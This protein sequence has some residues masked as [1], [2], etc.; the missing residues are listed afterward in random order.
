MESF[1]FPYMNQSALVF[2]SILSSVYVLVIGLQPWSYIPGTEA[3]ATS[4]TTVYSAGDT[5]SVDKQDSLLDID[6]IP[7][8]KE[9]NLTL[10]K[11]DNRSSF[12]IYILQGS[13]GNETA[14]FSS[15]NLDYPGKYILLRIGNVSSSEF[16]VSFVFGIDGVRQDY[17]LVLVHGPFS[18]PGWRNGTYF[19]AIS[20]NSARV[21]N[22]DDLLLF[23]NDNYTAIKNMTLVMQNQSNLDRMEFH[24]KLSNA[25]E[26]LPH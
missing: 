4:G 21:V 1:E 13:T 24:V 12:P 18:G 8:G 19:D 16:Q 20:P 25:I 15:Y 26:N 7:W 11:V 22:L 2:V 23:Y 9:N 6:F 5:V 3:A 10:N 14:G 17:R